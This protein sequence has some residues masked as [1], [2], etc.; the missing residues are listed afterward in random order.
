[1][2]VINEHGTYSILVVLAMHADDEAGLYRLVV[3]CTDLCMLA[4]ATDDWTCMDDDTGLI[5]TSD[6]EEKCLPN[7][8]VEAGMLVSCFSL[9]ESLPDGV[10]CT[11]RCVLALV[12]DDWI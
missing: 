8:A 6:A 7:D 5:F 10:D 3:G 4:L 1:M 11:D 9:T 12:P 2:V